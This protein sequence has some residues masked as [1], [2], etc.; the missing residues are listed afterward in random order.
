MEEFNKVTQCSTCYFMIILQVCS[1]RLP[2]PKGVDIVS[3][4][5]AAGHLSSASIYPACL[6]P[7]LIVTACSDGAVRFWNCDICCLEVNVGLEPNSMIKNNIMSW[8]TTSFEYAL[9]EEDNR[10]KPL[11]THVMT[12]EVADSC[13]T[14]QEW[15]MMGGQQDITSSLHIKGMLL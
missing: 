3:A 6:A 8:S 12:D 1:Q 11:M 7:Y 14:W 13:F 4:S 15:E 5:P 2:L 10:T 9:E